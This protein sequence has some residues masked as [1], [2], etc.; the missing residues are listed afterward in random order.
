MTEFVAHAEESDAG[1][2][3]TRVVAAPSRRVFNML[4]QVKL[5]GLATPLRIFGTAHKQR[6]AQ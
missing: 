4:D 5:H 3:G 2:K 1:G 6:N